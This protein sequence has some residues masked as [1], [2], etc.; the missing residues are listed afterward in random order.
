MKNSGVRVI[1]VLFLMTFVLVNSSCGTFVKQITT[2]NGT[3]D[4][5][6]NP[7][8]TTIT[9]DCLPGGG[10]CSYAG[11]PGGPQQIVCPS[12]S[13]GTGASS[14]PLITNPGPGASLSP[15][16]WCSSAPGVQVGSGCGG[17]SPAAVPPPGGGTDISGTYTGPAKGTGGNVSSQSGALT[18]HIT[19]TGS[20]ISGTWSETYPNTPV[21]SGTLTGTVSGSTV[22]LNMPYDAASIA[23]VP[24]TPCTGSSG[25]A[26]ISGNTLTG[27]DS[28]VPA[29]NATCS[30]QAESFTLTK[31]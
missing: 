16:G 7:G 31:Q 12:S 9:G 27:S 1:M 25:Q 2:S 10:G 30:S 11:I 21:S 20:Q 14:A 5:A 8:A 28:A 24:G 17:A 4:I 3:C 22:T 29:S 23:A 26:T 15:G 6:S 18:L 13:P 19:Q